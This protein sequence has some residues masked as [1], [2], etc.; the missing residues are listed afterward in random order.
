MKRLL[1]LTIMALFV[2][3]NLAEIALAQEALAEPCGGVLCMLL[4]NF[5]EVSAWAVALFTFLAVVLRASAELL[6]FISERLKNAKVGS[7]A[8]KI[9]SYAEWAAKILSWFGAGV[10]KKIIA[11]KIEQASVK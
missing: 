9:G 6:L 1:C 3:L 11:Q 8:S 7:L 4:A 10:P 5:P 2:F